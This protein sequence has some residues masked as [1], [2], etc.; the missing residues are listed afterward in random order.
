MKPNMVAQ[1]LIFYLRRPGF[2][3]MGVREVFK[4][5]GAD[6]ISAMRHRMT[7]TRKRQT[8]GV[9]G[10]QARPRIGSSGVGSTAPH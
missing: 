10:C 8:G 5:V 2:D 6:T 9:S 4:V 3:D 7:D 1:A